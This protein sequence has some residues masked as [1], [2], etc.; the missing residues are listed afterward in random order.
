MYTPR[1]FSSPAQETLLK[2]LPEASFATLLTSDEDGTPVASHLPFSYDPD[3]GELG[4]IRGHMARANPH[5][6]LFAGRQSL[7]IFA[8]PHIYVSPRDY[9]STVNVPTWNY[10][11]VHAYGEIETLED[12]NSVRS[13]L[14]TLTAENEKDRPIPWDLSEID[15]KRSSAMMKAIVAFEMPISRLEGKAKLGQNKSTE[16]KAALQKAAENSEIAGWQKGVL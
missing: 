3:V 5:W 13:V 10:V 8:G 6:K 16:D 12:E 4:T 1:H 7:I 15:E 14:D 9:A 11:A 2:I